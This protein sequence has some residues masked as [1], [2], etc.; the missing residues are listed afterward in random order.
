MSRHL[1]FISKYPDIVQ[2]FLHAMRE[3]DIQI[4]TASNGF[5]A[6]ARLKKMEY[7]VVVTGLSLDGYNGEQIITYLNKKHPNTVCIIYTT[8]ISPAQLHFFMNARDV[9]RVFLRPVDFHNEFFGALEEAFEY[10]DVQVKEAELAAAQS[11]ELEKKK[12]E[13]TMLE[14]RMK[15]QKQIQV[16]M[17]QY[18]KR[19]FAMS[20]KEYGTGLTQERY[21]QLRQIEWDTAEL[22][23]GRA[24]DIS[25]K[26][27]L[28][29][30]N[31]RRIK[32]MK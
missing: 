15:E 32:E 20:L 19:V 4:D 8:T 9:F 2:E 27:S 16:T 11:A 31:V 24:G 6:A 5:E 21:E 18:A 1:L 30:Q 26:L 23:C 22:C 13:I 17:E 29:E 25:E 3:K 28:A 7:E 10:Y 14:S 12:R